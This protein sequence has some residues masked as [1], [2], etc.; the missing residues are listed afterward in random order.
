ML[1]GRNDVLARGGFYNWRMRRMREI[2]SGARIRLGD[3]SPS[4]TP[5]DSDKRI[6]SL[7]GLYKRQFTGLT[8]LDSTLMMEG[9]PS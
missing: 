6:R 8:R 3:L 9:Q 4:D 1:R 2:I 5:V 7:Y